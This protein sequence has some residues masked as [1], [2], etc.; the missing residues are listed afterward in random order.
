VRLSTQ[1]VIDRYAGIPC[2]ALLSLLAE[3]FPGRQENTPK[4]I[5]VILLSEM[6]SLVL[7]LPMFDR[8]R[9][10]YPKAAFHA[11]VFER[12][13]EAMTLIKRVPR[14][15]I[16][17]IRDSSIGALLLDSFRAMCRL[18][19]ARIDTV[20]DCELFSRVSSV[21][22]YLCG[23]GVRAGFH[24]HRQEGLYRGNH[25]NRPVLYNP[26]MHIAE[27]FRTLAQSIAGSGSPL[28]K[29][30]SAGPPA[31][32]PPLPI[33]PASLGAF[34]T[35]L[36]RDFPGIDPN[37]L[38]LIYAGGGLLPIRAWPA[39]RYRRL[40]SELCAR[41]Y[42]VAAIGMPGDFALAAD[43]LADCPEGAGW[44]LAGYTKSIEELLALLHTARL[45]ITNDGGPAH[46]ASVTPMQIIILFGPE[47]P[48]LYRPLS[49]RATIFH[50]PL[51]CS[52]CLTAYNHRNSP[53]N[54]DNRCLTAI[55]VETVLESA[56]D[57]LPPPA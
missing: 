21:F 12:N 25:I 34:R 19:R 55:T 31:S 38:V 23:A 20:I 37:R 7:T 35:R 27:Q 8:L 24:R 9:E 57:R 41:G 44:N 10:Q 49:P 3:W 40:C 26:Y 54:G 32:L 47:T 43:I 48:V 29:E 39:A 53:C 6:G 15:N 52:P 42:T 36:H 14:E 11:L 4:R 1:R 22:S 46:F 30:P 45:L 18:R 33:S 2:C 5:L 51:A 17:T 13:R 56:L 50:T 28:V 16:V